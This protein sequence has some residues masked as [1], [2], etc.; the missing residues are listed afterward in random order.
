VTITLSIDKLDWMLDDIS[1][2][3]PKVPIKRIEHGKLAHFNRA[4]K[5]DQRTILNKH[6]F[7]SELVTTPFNKINLNTIQTS[8]VHG[9]QS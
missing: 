1:Y 6:I 5:Q 7:D 3:R 4:P 2:Q 8:N 9:Q